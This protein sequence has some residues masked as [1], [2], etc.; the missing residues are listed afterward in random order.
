MKVSTQP[1]VCASDVSKKV[2]VI[3]LAMEGS[4][5]EREEPLVQ[6]KYIFLSETQSSSTESSQVRVPSG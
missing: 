5:D 2:D 3:G 1:C 4:Y 6:G